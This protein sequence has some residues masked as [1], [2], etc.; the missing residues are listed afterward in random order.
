M[1][2]LFR[3]IYVL[4]ILA[5]ALAILAATPSAGQADFREQMAVQ[6]LDLFNAARSDPAGAAAAIGISAGQ[7]AAIRPELTSAPEQGLPPLELE[8][9]LG[10]TARRHTAHMLAGNRYTY[11]DPDGIPLAERLRRAGYVPRLA[12]ESIGLVGFFNFIDPRQAVG[13]IFDTLLRRELD[14]SREAP[15]TFLHPAFQHVG[16]GFDSGP[17]TL[18]G[19]TYNAYLVTCYF[20]RPLVF[21]NSEK[22]QMARQLA[23]LIN[24]FRAD[25]VGVTRSLG[26]DASDLPAESAYSPDA[27]LY[28]A[29][30]PLV[31]SAAL[32]L[33]AAQ[34]ADETAGD[35]QGG[36][37]PSPDHLAQRLAEAGYLPAQSSHTVAVAAR[38]DLGD[39][40]EAVDALFKDLVLGELAY[41]RTLGAVKLLDEQASDIGIGIAATWA[42]G[43]A[44][45]LAAT[46]L[47]G[48]AAPSDVS[49]IVGSVYLDRDENW[50][51]NLGEGL[52]G[53][54][55]T[56][57]TESPTGDHV[58]ALRETVTNDVGAFVLPI[59][60]RGA[61]QVRMHI[62]EE[63]PGTYWVLTE[64]ANVFLDHPLMP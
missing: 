13:Q 61:Y 21:D 25:P 37:S 35:P 22:R 16:I 33:V 23:V 62:P 44:G 46:V 51:H 56:I 58:T 60:Q 40:R 3:N 31:S 48:F 45:D 20:G 34:L 19:R 4:S 28:A 47:I 53:I 18:N 11:D 30:P 57:A 29:T 8:A 14:P 49:Y 36:L 59:D 27:I 55:V 42:D 10:G 39:G 6:L 12:G 50:L 38:P 15:L 17:M 63:E 43:T 24:Q 9:I 7:L 5:T 2:R 64:G 52:V 32:E 1:N 26:L 54:K 41:H